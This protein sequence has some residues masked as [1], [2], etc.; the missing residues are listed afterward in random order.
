MKC[1]QSFLIRITQESMSEGS[2]RHQ[3]INTIYLAHV[4][5]FT[6]MKFLVSI[7]HH[8]SLHFS[9]FTVSCQHSKP[10]SY[11]FYSFF[12]TFIWHFS[13]LV[14][15]FLIQTRF[16]YLFTDMYFMHHFINNNTVVPP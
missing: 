7:L 12:D 10:V 2:N 6:T 8:C 15:L 13:R 5:L 1:S 9:V 4:F 11:C 16:T 3:W 14:K